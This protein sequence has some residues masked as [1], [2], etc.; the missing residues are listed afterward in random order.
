MGA[1]PAVAVPGAAQRS[2][3]SWAAAAA[4]VVVVVVLVAVAV[5]VA[6]EVGLDPGWRRS[7]G[8]KASDGRDD[9]ACQEQM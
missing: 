4:A 9:L 7:Y 5:A 1:Y 6:V 3:T 2:R 8:L